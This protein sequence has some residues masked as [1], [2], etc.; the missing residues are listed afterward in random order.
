MIE[1]IELYQSSPVF[2]RSKMFSDIKLNE[3]IAFYVKKRFTT[4]RR[5]VWPLLKIYA[6]VSATK[7]L[8][9]RAPD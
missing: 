1:I 9:K 5:L 8:I 4:Y 2:M 3:N 7:S 6:I